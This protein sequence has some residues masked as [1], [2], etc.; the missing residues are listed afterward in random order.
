[1]MNEDTIKGK[2]LEMKGEI[3]NTWGKLTDDEVSKSEG[4]AASILGLIQQKY[5]AKKEEIEEKLSGI[6]SR[7]NDKAE[8]FKQDLKKDDSEKLH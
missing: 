1:M 6:M 4:N 3:L 2:W 5:G 7:F 8:N